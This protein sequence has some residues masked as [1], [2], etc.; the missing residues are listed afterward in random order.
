MRKLSTHNVRTLWESRTIIMKRADIMRCASSAGGRGKRPSSS[1]I[2]KGTTCARST[3][4]RGNRRTLSELKLIF[5][6]RPGCSQCRRMYLPEDALHK[7]FRRF[8]EK[9]GPDVLYQGI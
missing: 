4:S 9:L 5:K 3:G 7:V 6:R 8:Q 2:G 1:D